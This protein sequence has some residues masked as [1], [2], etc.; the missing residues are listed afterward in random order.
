MFKHRSHKIPAL[1]TTST[2]DISFMLLIF[3]L[4][5]TSMDRDQGL[6][7]QLPPMDNEKQEQLTDVSRENVM[8]LEI[9]ERGQLF[10]DDSLTSM[11]QVRQRIVAFAGQEQLRT[12]HILQVKTAPKSDYDTYFHLQNEIVAA[13][14]QLREQRAVKVYHKAYSRCSE[15]QR[16]AL[17]QYYPQR[18]A[19]EYDDNVNDNVNHNPNDN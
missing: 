14:R 18:V 13:Y 10:V 3:F 15:S 4:V 1:N 6:Q 8:K 9:D 19:E 5:T 11:K 12:K 7:R 16:E 17:Q 2:A